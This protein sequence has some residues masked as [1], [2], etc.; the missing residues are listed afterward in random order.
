MYK[1]I[2]VPVDNSEYSDAAIELAI[3][4]GKAFGASLVGNHVYAGKLHEHRFRQMEYTLPP[5][6]QGEEQ[7]EKQRKIHDSLITMGL[8]LISDSYLEVMVQKAQTAGLTCKKVILNGKNYVELVRDIQKSNYDLVVM[9]A[10]GIGAVKGSVCERVARRIQ[11]DTLVVKTVVPLDTS[12]DAPIMVGIDGSPQSYAGLQSAI[13]LGKA[14]NR[15]VEAVGV[16][17]PFLHYT[18]FNRL[19]D[20]LTEKAARVFKFREQ[21]QLHEE[22]IDTGLARIY[23]SHLEVAREVARDHGM[24]LK[25]TLLEGKAFERI[26]RYVHHTEPWM[27]VLGRIGIHGDEGLDIGFNTE[28]LL[29]LAPCHVLI[30]SRKFRPPMDVRAEASVAWTPEAEQRMEKVPALVKAI[31]RA[32]VL[33]FALERGHSVIT[34]SLIDEVMDIFMPGRTVKKAQKL[35][36]ELAIESIRA[37]DTTVYLCQVCG[38]TVRDVQP[39]VCVV[40]SADTTKFQK[41]DKVSVETLEASEGILQEEETF[42]GIK[43]CWTAEAKQIL[44]MV[45]S[46]YVRRRAKA[47]IEKTARVQRVEAIGKE[48]AWSIIAE[49]LEDQRELQNRDA[50]TPDQYLLK[51]TRATG[52]TDDLFT[53][54][55]EAVAR[56]NRVPEGYM[57]N[58]T[59]K[60]VEEM[61]TEWATREITLKIVEDG[62]E[63]G[64]KMMAEMIK[65]YNETRTPDK[66]EI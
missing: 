59:K 16:Y 42:D 24:D 21:E 8:Q 52:R 12:S 28:N 51:A 4:L 50:L 9:G 14:F 57:R 32:A 5:R 66:K 56:L 37:S 49:I 3:A 53:W 36:V 7:L 26:I 29:R 27:L 22:I 54:T 48:L 33:R 47:Q 20:V 62:I 10:L 60:R 15:R 18:V 25:I 63:I 58:M 46:G 64:K 35:A 17:D 38:H 11:T 40:C 30:T 41:L 65:T 31:A 13:A 23:Q 43:L 45:P 39:A 55:E 2:C 19:A 6:Y 44:Q 1:T 34:N 61:A